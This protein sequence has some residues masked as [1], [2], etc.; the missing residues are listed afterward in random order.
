M[1]AGVDCPGKT[2]NC[3]DIVKAKFGHLLAGLLHLFD[4][5]REVA[6]LSFFAKNVEG[7]DYSYVGSW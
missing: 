7:M 2:L 4:T 1:H 6:Q 3:H 5:R